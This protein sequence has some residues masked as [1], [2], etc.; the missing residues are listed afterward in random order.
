MT[1]EKKTESSQPVT[2]REE[3]EIKIDTKPMEDMLERTQKAEK[4]AQGF[5]EI[6]KDLSRSFEREGVYINPEDIN[7]DNYKDY[8]HKLQIKKNDTEKKL[9]EM[10]NQDF[11]GVGS[12]SDQ[13]GKGSAGRSSLDGQGN[14]YT[15]DV[16]KKVYNSESEMFLDVLTQAEAGNEQMKKIADKMLIKAVQDNQK[17]ATSQTVELDIPLKEVL[18]IKNKALRKKMS[19]MK[20]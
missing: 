1:L 19:E 14:Q 4:D 6:A 11:D 10:E 17:R 12:S 7:R 8:I 16:K 9:Q 13:T 15:G 2:K 5:R 3:F 20:K 18:D